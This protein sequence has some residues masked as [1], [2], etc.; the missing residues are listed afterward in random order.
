[1]QRPIIWP[2]DE[3]TFEHIKKQ[4]RITAKRLKQA[5]GLNPDPILVEELKRVH[6]AYKLLSNEESRNF[7][8]T[9]DGIPQEPLNEEET[10]HEEEHVE[11]NKETEGNHVPP[12]EGKPAEEIPQGINLDPEYRKV[13]EEWAEILLRGFDCDKYHQNAEDYE[14]RSFFG[15]SV[16]GIPILSTINLTGFE[17]YFESQVNF[18]VIEILFLIININIYRY[19]ILFVP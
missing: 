17:F 15:A 4:Y 1:L 3:V 9:Y 2:S 12:D 18:N 5:S 8:H 13:F 7:Y 6:A 19:N 16:Y 11:E 14:L 10:P